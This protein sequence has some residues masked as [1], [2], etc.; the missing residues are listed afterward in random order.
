VTT[1]IEAGTVQDP[2]NLPK[3]LVVAELG[4]FS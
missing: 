2:Q 4:C 3:A 1:H